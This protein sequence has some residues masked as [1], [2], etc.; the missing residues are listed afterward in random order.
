MVA[1]FGFELPISAPAIILV[2]IV[3]VSTASAVII[4]PAIVSVID[5]LPVD[6]LQPAISVLPSDL[7]RLTAVA[8]VRVALVNDVTVSVTA[9]AIP[10][11]V[12][13]RSVSIDSA[14]GSVVRAVDVP[15]AAPV[16][17]PIAVC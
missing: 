7:D 17:H 1:A 14:I 6:H 2:A 5:T 11:A 12:V 8:I 10:T 16:V 15:P 3:V 9:D 4:N 13:A